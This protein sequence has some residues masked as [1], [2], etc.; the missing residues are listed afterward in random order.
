MPKQH[1]ATTVNESGVPVQYARLTLN[2]M[3]GIAEIHR[4]HARSQGIAGSDR[5]VICERVW[6]A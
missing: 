3:T 1:T 4:S 2:S 6:Q 5:S